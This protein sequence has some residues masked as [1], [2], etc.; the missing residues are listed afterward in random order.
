[1]EF[2]YNELIFTPF[3]YNYLL[4]SF[5]FS[6]IYQNVEFPSTADSQKEKIKPYLFASILFIIPF[7][8]WYNISFHGWYYPASV[9]ILDF[10]FGL[11][12]FAL[13]TRINFLI[14]KKRKKLVLLICAI[15][16]YYL[17]KSIWI[18]TAFIM[19]FP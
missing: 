12:V 14:F 1:M 10:I 6:V 13:S 8:Q 3:V 15:L 16:S 11:L 5:L 9:F 18:D 4:V 2:N 19:T 17:I 7:L